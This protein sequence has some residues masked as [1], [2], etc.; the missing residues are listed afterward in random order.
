MLA[1][2]NF[3]GACVSGDQLFDPQGAE[4]AAE[5]VFVGCASGNGVDEGRIVINLSPPAGASHQFIYRD[6]ILVGTT[7]G[8]ATSYID[9]GLDEGT[10]HQYRCDAEVNHRTATGSGQLQLSTLTTHAP[11][12]AGATAATA[13]DGSHLK[14][15][16]DTATPGAGPVWGYRVYLNMGTTVDWTATP[17]AT[18]Q[19]PAAIQQIFASLGDQI[20]YSAGVRACSVG[21][22]CDTNMVEK[23]VTLPDWGAPTS[24]AISGLSQ[25]D[26]KV[27]LAVPWTESN[28]GITK[29]TVYFRTGAT[30]GTVLAQYGTHHIENVT[31][32]TNP[33]TSIDVTGLTENTQY[34]FLVVDQDAT[35]HTSTVGTPV[36][37]TTTDL[38]LPVFS[39]STSVVLGANQE[40]DAVISY[41]TI[42]NE[43]ENA[44]AGTANYLLYQTSAP[45]PAPPAD[46]CAS[47]TLV[48]TIS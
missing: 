30:G 14:V 26:G 34:W 19:D 42:A 39:G 17:R 38:T 1:G 4:K 12:F 9:V 8:S 2:A 13:I 47:G 23:H 15:T 25:Q 20:P 11:T 31:D 7:T 33:K 48:Q 29:R 27:V 21:P 41:T 16:W 40:H 44:A 22:V 37:I 35:G 28:G 6:G 46:P 36:T 10:T 18:V 5:I 24:G 45:Y 32:I 3:I 43:T